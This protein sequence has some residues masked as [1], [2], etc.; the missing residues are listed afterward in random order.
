MNGYKARLVIT[1][2]DRLDVMEA[3][4]A[5]Y[6]AFGVDINARGDVK[7]E[8]RNGWHKLSDAE[9]VSLAYRA[10]SL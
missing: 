5:I 8:T 7:V 1:A 2:L 10:R 9:L 4:R 3:V 6:N